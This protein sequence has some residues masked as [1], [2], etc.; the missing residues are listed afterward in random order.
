[1]RMVSQADDLQSRQ[2]A[3]NAKTYLIWKI[4]KKCFKMSSTAVVIGV[5][6]VK[7]AY[8]IC[9]FQHYKHNEIYMYEQDVNTRIY[10][11]SQI[12]LH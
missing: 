4:T 12:I 2:S 6:R 3:W 9:S 7:W 1:M 11:I 10:K 5:L 8:N